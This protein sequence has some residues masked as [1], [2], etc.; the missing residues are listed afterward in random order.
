MSEG[1]ADRALSGNDRFA[2][3]VTTAAP[4]CGTDC[5]VL[6]KDAHVFV[7]I[8]LHLT[9]SRPLIDRPLVH[10][11]LNAFL[12]LGDFRRRSTR[13]ADSRTLAA[14]EDAEARV[15]E[16]FTVCVA[17]FRNRPSHP[18]LKRIVI[19]SECRVRQS[20]TC[21]VGFPI[22]RLL[23]VSTELWYA[24]VTLHTPTRANHV[25]SLDRVHDGV[26]RTLREVE[27]KVR[28][29]LRVTDTTRHPRRKVV[30]HPTSLHD[31]LK[32]FV[33]V[34]FLHRALVC[35]FGVCALEGVEEP[36]NG[37][38]DDGGPHDGRSDDVPLV[39]EDGLLTLLFAQTQFV[40]EEGVVGVNDFSE[41]RRDVDVPVSVLGRLAHQFLH[42]GGESR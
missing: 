16:Q 15:A 37:G 10:L 27:G 20:P 1:R 40:R 36:K 22:T 18:R 6:Q 32:R 4:S 35:E 33:D 23:E 25:E 28:L 30:A 8:L 7:H 19:V 42:E 41:Q 14:L 13:D 39:I 11:V 3:S 17:R 24:H 5:V 34:G 26:S 29:D 21:F 2:R 9:H 12:P 31:V 38:C